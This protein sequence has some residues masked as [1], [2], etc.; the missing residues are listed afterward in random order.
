M[1]IP[2]TVFVVLSGSFFYFI[3]FLD[4]ESGLSM[5]LIAPIVLCT[6]LSA[7]IA[8]KIGKSFPIYWKT[9]YKQKD[10]DCSVDRIEQ[11]TALFCKWHYYFIA[12][13]PPDRKVHTT[14][15]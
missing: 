12:L 9:I 4:S 3:K 11:Q 13:P 7:S 14:S 5:C 2:L 10:P 6:F 1:L 15:L 8:R